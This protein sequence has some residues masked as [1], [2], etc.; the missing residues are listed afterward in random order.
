LYWV[1]LISPLELDNVAVENWKSSYPSTGDP[2][3]G[4]AGVDAF[5]TSRLLMFVSLVLE[6]ANNDPCA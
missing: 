3:S 6:H 5:M 2:I 1:T 4:S